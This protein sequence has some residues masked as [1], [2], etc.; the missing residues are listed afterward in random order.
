MRGCLMVG[1]KIKLE[2]VKILPFGCILGDEEILLPK[3]YVPCGAKIGDSVE[4]FIYTDSQDRI[5][6]TTLEP[7]GILGEIVFLEVVDFSEYGVFLDLGIAKDILMPCKNP[8]RYAKG[9]KIAVQIGKDREGRLLANQKL[10]FCKYYG[11]PFVQFD[12]MPY[13]KTPLGFECVVCGKFQGMLFVNEVF[14]DLELGKTY[15]VQ[16]KKTRKDGKIDLKLVQKGE[17][18]R[19]LDVLRQNHGKIPITKDSHPQEI[20]RVCQMSKKAFKRALVH[21]A[22][23]VGQ[24]EEGIYLR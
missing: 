3:K 7:Y 21:L 2:I 1:T 12:A 22:Q 16:V 23:E 20:V 17:V 19:L 18:E 13:R 10:R 11:K 24:D 8:Q 14:E 15:R 9:S 4:V 5:I 6:A